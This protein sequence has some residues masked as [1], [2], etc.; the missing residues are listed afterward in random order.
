MN[1]NYEYYRIFYYVAKY[2]SFTKAA[3]VLYANQP[4]IT[5]T[6]N[7]LESELGCRLLERTHQ[8]VTLTPEGET[9]FSHIEI[10]HEAI[11]QGE[12]E[13]SGIT[14][15][16]SG[17]VSIGVS[18]TALNLFL[19]EKLRS[20]HKSYPGI[21]LR[22]H[23]HSTPQAVSA[24]EQG[25]IDLA[26]VTMPIP[27][28][29]H[30]RKI[31]LMP[32]QEILLGGSDFEALSHRRLHL[33]ELSDYPLIMMGKDTMTYAFYN[34]LFLDHGLILKAAAE[35]ATTDQI[36]PL[37]QYNL[38]LGFLPETFAETSIKKGNVY[39]ISIHETIPP[40]N[41]VMIQDSRRPLSIAARAFSDTLRSSGRADFG[42]SE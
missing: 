39:P 13:L 41:I 34:Q 25:S 31:P 20:F 15:L 36:L 19:I 26:I 38:G 2:K 42:S 32:F 16:Q 11:C 3:N 33:S 24:L 8:G 12:N 28:S 9:L 5:R 1:V 37:I 30:M 10:A 29:K 17:S 6:I 18:E 40:R 22:I 21:F 27:L 35:V 14:T 23:N 7:R 4:N